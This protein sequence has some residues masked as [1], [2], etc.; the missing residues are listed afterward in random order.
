MEQRPSQ[1][2]LVWLTRSFAINPAAIVA[3]F[4]GNAGQ[5]ELYLMGHS[6]HFKESDLTE[7]GRAL[8][9]PPPH[10]APAPSGAGPG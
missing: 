5:V 3:V 1:Q 2:P 10:R 9:V 7:E 8:L 4:H 6:R